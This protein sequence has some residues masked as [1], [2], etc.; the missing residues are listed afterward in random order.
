MIALA[1]PVSIFAFRLPKRVI[2]IETLPNL[3]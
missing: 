3:N 1:L 2:N